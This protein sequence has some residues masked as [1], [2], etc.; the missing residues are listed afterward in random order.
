M[1]LLDYDDSAYSHVDTSVD[2]FDNVYFS[3]VPPESSAA[4]GDMLAS[5]DITND[6][7]YSC[8]LCEKTYVKRDSLMR[9]IKSHSGHQCTSC[10]RVFR[11][12]GQLYDHKLEKHSVKNKMCRICGKKFIEATTLR[13]HIKTHMN[14]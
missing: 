11:T 12:P 9:H 3:A 1:T 5:A 14:F 7:Y 13:K 4:V 10:S 6:P 2:V 8:H